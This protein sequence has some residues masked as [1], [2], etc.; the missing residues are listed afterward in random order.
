MI[1]LSNGLSFIRAPL[2]LLFLFDNI[3]LRLTAIALAAFTDSIDGY[4]ARKNKSV[5]KFGAILDPAMDKFFVYF[6]L[7]IFVMENNIQIWQA[8][9][10]LSRDLAL[11]IFG[12]YLGVSKKWASYVVK[13]IRW[14]KITTA[15]QFLVLFALT[16]HFSFGWYVYSLFIVLGCLAFFELLH[17]SYYKSAL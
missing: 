2:A 11:C 12:I 6:V 1:T 4:V 7:T 3:P 10:L 16:I 13:A 9:T 17:S 5:S 8:L 15:L 14:G